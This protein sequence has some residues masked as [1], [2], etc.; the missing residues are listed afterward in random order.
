MKSPSMILVLMTLLSGCAGT[1]SDLPGLSDP[2]GTDWA[3]WPV[4]TLKTYNRPFVDRLIDELAAA[5]PD[6]ALRVCVAD[7]KLLRRQI[8]AINKSQTACQ[9]MRQK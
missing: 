6:S 4:P 9:L 2:S 1:G 7:L 3:N 8:C 5:P